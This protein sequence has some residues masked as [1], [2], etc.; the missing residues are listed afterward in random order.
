[1]KHYICDECT[2][3]FPKDGIFY[4]PSVKDSFTLC[5]NCITSLELERYRGYKKDIIKRL[6]NHAKA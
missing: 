5:V 6:K 1:M 4:M 2:G 3:I